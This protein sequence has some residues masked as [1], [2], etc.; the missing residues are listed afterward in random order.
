MRLA[1]DGPAAARMLGAADFSKP[2]PNRMVHHLPQSLC[3][4]GQ[5]QHMG[6]LRPEAAAAVGAVVV[7][8]DGTE[9]G[10]IAVS[11][12]A[13]RM[14]NMVVNL[15]RFRSPVVVSTGFTLVC[16]RIGNPGSIFTKEIMGFES[17][18]IESTLQKE[19]DDAGYGW[20]CYAAP[21]TTPRG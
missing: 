5:G 6:Q 1:G 9:A 3:P 20:R 14:V 16:A 10:E 18:N 11:S 2:P 19:G 12:N 15:L 7:V 17:G 8:C 13:N 4:I 21:G